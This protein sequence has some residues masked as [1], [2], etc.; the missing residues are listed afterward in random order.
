M[1][2]R[3]R[4]VAVN[5]NW[6]LIPYLSLA[7]FRPPL[8]RPSALPSIESQFSTQIHLVCRVYEELQLRA[9]AIILHVLP[10]AS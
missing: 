9:T 8:A 7:S 2:G 10:M 5:A 4:A 6:H 3:E 1:T